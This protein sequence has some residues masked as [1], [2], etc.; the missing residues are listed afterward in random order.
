MRAHYST[1]KVK[2]TY[3]NLRR[4]ILLGVFFVSRPWDE[5]FTH[6]RWPELIDK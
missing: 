4:D 6:M 5:R 2:S 3:V 1:G